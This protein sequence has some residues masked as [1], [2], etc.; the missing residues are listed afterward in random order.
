MSGLS[1]QLERI[2]RRLAALESMVL[3]PPPDPDP[4][5]S[6]PSATP[7]APSMHSETSARAEFLRPPS[8]S[9]ITNIL[10][11]G[12]AAAL[13]LAASYLI[14][15]VYD[16][17]WLTPVRQVGLAAALGAGLVVA[18]FPL[19]RTYARYAGYLPAAGV[20]ALF[21]TVYGAQLYHHLI[22]VPA[23]MAAVIAVCLLSLWLCT[24]FEGDLYALFA[25]A[26][27][28]SAPLLLHESGGTVASLV[29][30]FTAWSLVFGAFSIRRRRRG[31]YLFAV[32]LALVTFD[33]AWFN[34]SRD[35]WVAALLFQ[36]VQFMIFGV[37]TMRYSMRWNEPLTREMTVAH[38]PPMVLFYFLQYALLDRHLHTW[39]PWIAAASAALVLGLYLTAKRAMTRPTPGGELLLWSYVAIVA[40]HA[41]YVESVPD[42]W[43]PWVAAGVLAVAAVVGAML[44]D[45]ETPLGGQWPI[46][47]AAGFVI[48][49]N[50]LRVVF[51]TEIDHVPGRA[52]L[53][54]VYAGEFYAAYFFTRQV[55]TR[56]WPV[57]L[58]YAG[59]LSAMAAAVRLIDEPIVQ[60]ATWAVVAMACLG[61]AFRGRERALGQS[62]LVFF[63]AAAVK[64]LL[65][66]L[67]GAH[68]LWR[69]ASLVVLG[70]M[71]YGGGM[72]YQR[73]VGEATEGAPNFT[74]S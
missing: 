40:F 73:M 49:A 4:P 11:W 67:D 72:L 47:A 39:A 42:I 8:T 18:G 65:F 5:P 7:G 69:I 44:L 6:T 1:E 56:R 36:T 26:G 50:Y 14:K 33:V 62:S 46:W 45:G 19:R 59:H 55:V 27:S 38:L 32:Y 64:V 41:G 57:A 16:S 9:F 17:G 22:G 58:L 66:D 30:Y 13:V 20:G 70:V 2:E 71:F 23:A 24:E 12:G 29:I 28:Y 35:E 74:R 61:L 37:A 68:P 15:L 21:I 3:P 60:S 31:I 10:G 48:L 63:G 54:V 52:A 53:S 34:T 43:G 25:V 51:G